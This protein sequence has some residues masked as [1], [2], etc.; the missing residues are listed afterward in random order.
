VIL[1]G[2]FFF[3]PLAI[4][5]SEQ[6]KPRNKIDLKQLILPS[7]ISNLGKTT[8]SIYYSPSVKGKV[9]IPVH[10]WGEVSKSGLHYIPVGTT[11]INGLSLAGGPKNAGNLD[12]VKLTRNTGTQVEELKFD[13]TEG[14]TLTAYREELQAGDTIFIPKDTFREDRVYYTS[15]VGVAA[16]IIS[17]LFLLRQLED[18]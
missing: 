1:T 9:L 6:Q 3:T 7:E 18:R 17:S 14:G 15:L 5:K 4:A 10:F 11:L 16:T 13:L 8:G 12:E 2:H